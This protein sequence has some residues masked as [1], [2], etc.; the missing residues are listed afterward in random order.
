MIV[1]WTDLNPLYLQAGRCCC[2]R[3]TG[4]RGRGNSSGIWRYEVIIKNR[5]QK[6]QNKKIK[7]GLYRKIPYMEIPY[8][9]QMVTY[10]FALPWFIPCIYRSRNKFWV[11]KCFE[12]IYV[13]WVVLLICVGKIPCSTICRLLSTINFCFRK[14]SPFVLS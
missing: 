14:K 8:L 10:D 13:L 2:W 5:V 3:R 1:I 7:R 4:R 11:L 6:S 12:Y 9:Q